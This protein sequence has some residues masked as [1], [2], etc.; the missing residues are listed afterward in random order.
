M[1]QQCTCEAIYIAN[2]STPLSLVSIRIKILSVDSRDTT[3]G[4]VNR[5]RLCNQGITAR[6][7]KEARKLLLLT[8]GIPQSVLWT[9]NGC[10]TKGSRLDSWRKREN[11]YSRKAS[12]LDLEFNQTCN[13]Y[14]ELFLHK[15]SCW[16]MW[17]R[18]H[19]F[20]KRPI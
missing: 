3:V 17:S 20:V 10:V 11:C 9:G 18:S 1:S 7:L 4:T 12:A 2:C 15:W 8:A 14:E 19:A 16:G 13:G 6:F 5:E